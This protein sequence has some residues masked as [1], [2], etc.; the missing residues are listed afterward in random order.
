MTISTA[1][2]E[3]NIVINHYLH[4]EGIEEPLQDILGRLSSSPKSISSMYFYDALGSKLFEDIT[5]LPEYYP[6]RTE[7]PLIKKAAS[8]IESWENL[9]IIEIGSGD[10]SKISLL[11]DAIS[12]KDLTTVRYI[13]IDVSHTAI[14]ESV[15]ILNSRYPQMEIHG[16]VADFMTQLDMI[17]SGAEKRLFCFFGSTIGNFDREIS[18]L[19][20]EEVATVMNPGDRLLLGVD[21]VKDVEILEKAY[22]DAQGVTAQFNLNILDVVNDLADTNFEKEHFEHLA[23]YNNEKHRIEMHLRAKKTMTISTPHMEKDITIM[24]GETIHT[25]NS[26]KFSETGLHHLQKESGLTIEKNFVDSREWF[27]LIQFCKEGD[28][29]N[30]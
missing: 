12:D 27:S 3:S 15:D 29:T 7:K 23:F 16:M 10:S 17:P 11:F 8:E 13:P 21:R 18:K 20:L 5:S 14:K 25:E 2:I 6:T 26:C 22:N 30:A 1:A 9:D 24:E 19:F 4:S 28:E